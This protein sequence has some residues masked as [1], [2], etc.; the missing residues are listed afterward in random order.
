MK[1]N[2]SNIF[3]VLQGTLT[4]TLTSALLSSCCM[5]LTENN[6]GRCIPP[7]EDYGYEFI[8]PLRLTPAKDTY[9]IGDTLYFESV[10]SHYV[11]ERTTGRRFLLEN[12]NWN[13]SS[14]IYRLNVDKLSVDGYFDFEVIVPEEYYFA[15]VFY[16]SYTHY[17]QGGERVYDTVPV[18]RYFGKYNYDGMRYT[19]KF[20][21]VAGDTGVY[22]FKYGCQEFRLLGDE[23]E[24]KKKCPF[25]D[26]RLSVVLNDGKDNNIHLLKE[27]PLEYYNEW[28]LYK[29]KDRF[30]GVGGYCFVVVE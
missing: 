3:T 23:I 1:A 2:N 28:I 19:L 20:Q 13:P 24:F 30:Y 17:Q 15:G 12:V 18:V 6:C 9:H 29:P 22:F 4:L 16:K 5:L 7:G 8:I 26:V 25:S 11:Y 10:F 21:L 27:S 14:Y